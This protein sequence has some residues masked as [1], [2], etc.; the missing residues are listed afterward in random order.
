MNYIVETFSTIDCIRLLNGSSGR[1]NPFYKHIKAF[2]YNDMISSFSCSNGNQLYSFLFNI[3][4]NLV[5]SYLSFLFYVKREETFF[6]NW[7]ISAI[8]IWDNYLSV[9]GSYGKGKE[10]DYFLDFF[11]DF[12]LNVIMSVICS[13]DFR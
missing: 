9:D 13:I 7:S 11:R 4:N 5:D 10:A 3:A 12:W 6:S 1:T 8:I 2:S